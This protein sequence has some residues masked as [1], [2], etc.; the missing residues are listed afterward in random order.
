MVIHGIDNMTLAD[1]EGAVAA[2]GRF[3]FYEYCISIIL[4]SARRPSDICFLRRGDW[5]IMRGLPYCL[6]SLL[7]GWW[8]IPWGLIY[9]PLSLF[10]N[11]S[12]GCDV[13]E[14]VLIYLQ[15]QAHPESGPEARTP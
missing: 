3:V 7:L 2:G 11:L 4:A 1:I 9:T 12:G 6:V 15:S 14:E 5:G 13:T 8:G 10:N